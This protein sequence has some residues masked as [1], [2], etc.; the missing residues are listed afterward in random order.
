MNILL[1]QNT[2]VTAYVEWGTRAT[3][4]LMDVPP[5]EGKDVQ[6]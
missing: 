6:S 2:W 3:D 1:K 4:Q 5:D